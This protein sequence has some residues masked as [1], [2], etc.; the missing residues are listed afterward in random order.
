MVSLPLLSVG[1][2]LPVSASGSKF[3]PKPH[4]NSNS[5]ND[6]K[7]Q[8]QQLEVSNVRRGGGWG[9]ARYYFQKQLKK[10]NRKTN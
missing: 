9:E 10:K 7:K 2:P 5:N 1:P 4:N 6:N 3:Q 8:E